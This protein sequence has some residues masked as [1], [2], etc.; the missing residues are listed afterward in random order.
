MT[1]LMSHHS[2]CQCYVSGIDNKTLCLD[3]RQMDKITLDMSV[4]MIFM[5]SQVG[6]ISSKVIGFIMAIFSFRGSTQINCE[7]D[8]QSN[9]VDNATDIREGYVIWYNAHDL[10]I[11][12]FSISEQDYYFR[13]YVT[14]FIFFNSC[15]SHSKIYSH[16]I[17]FITSGIFSHL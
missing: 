15:L 1:P 13:Y 3:L 14:E 9:F 12:W 17:V 2:A 11:C 5:E 4:L 8:L 10:L 7:P 6:H 16:L